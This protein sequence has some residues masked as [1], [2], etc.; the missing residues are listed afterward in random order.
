[1]I[2]SAAL[3]S[4]VIC[5]VSTAM[6]ATVFA[7]TSAEQ[8]QLQ[9]LLYKVSPSASY[10]PLTAS[11]S[12]SAQIL[13]VVNSTTIVPDSITYYPV[14]SLGGATS[15][16]SSTPGTTTLSLVSQEA[17]IEAL[18]AKIILLKQILAN[19]IQTAAYKRTDIATQAP[20]V[21]AAPTGPDYSACPKISKSLQVGAVGSEVTTLQR[22]LMQIGFLPD[23]SD[24]G[25]FDINTEAAVQRFQVREGIISSGSAS[26]TGYGATGPKTRT[27]LS[28]CTLPAA[29]PASA[30]TPAVPE[31]APSPIPVP[32]A[33]TTSTDVIDL[34]P[35]PLPGSL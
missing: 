7:L 5:L 11:S 29:A 17:A 21:E 9:S 23:E 31:Q 1:M 20:K 35:V 15:S 34:T 28:R 33:A 19:L 6:P 25:S 27:V 8:E 18:Q 10:I 22:F 4:F 30:T 24:T 32:A 16:A 3:A 12:V 26:T 14:G 13:D 2:R